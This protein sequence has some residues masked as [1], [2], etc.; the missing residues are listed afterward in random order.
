MALIHVDHKPR[1]QW[2]VKG[3]LTCLLTLWLMLGLWG[4]CPASASVDDD[5]LDGN[6][7]VVYAGN[8]SLVPAKLTLMDS[9]KR[10]MPT[11]LVF[12]LDDSRD[13][14]QFALI[15]SRIQEF[16]GRAANIIPVSVDGIPVKDNYTP[17]EAGYYYKG[18]VPQTVVLDQQGKLIFDGKG[19][20]RYEAVD[21]VLREVFNLLPRSQSVELKR[22]T[23][24][25]FNGELV[26]Q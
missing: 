14:K 10:E 7:F 22:R 21:D 17:Q 9:L 3:C 8:G 13:C 26:E 11:V 5:R 2:V 19:Q 25:E 6:I 20:V 24:N 18:A 23:F 4:I 15:V 16:Y 12:Y 1:S